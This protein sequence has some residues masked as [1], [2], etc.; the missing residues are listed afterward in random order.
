MI[1]AT[2][3]Q[4]EDPFASACYAMLLAAQGSPRPS[5]Q[6]GLV[7]KTK[8]LLQ[9]HAAVMAKRPESKAEQHQD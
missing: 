9:M 1:K 3:N 7:A 5:N 4:V 8:I 2:D 6:G